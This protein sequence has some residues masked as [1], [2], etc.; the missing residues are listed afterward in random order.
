MLMAKNHNLIFLAIFCLFNASCDGDGSFQATN[1]FENKSGHKVTVEPYFNNVLK[2]PRR[3]ELAK[4]AI[5]LVEQ[6]SGRG[7][8]KGYIYGEVVG[9][10]IVVIFD[11]TLKISHLGL[12]KKVSPKSYAY[13]HQRNL[14]NRNSYTHT[15]LES[16]KK[17]ADNEYRYIF[18]IADYQDALRLNK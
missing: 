15:I 18:T 5:V 2:I 3:F 12:N 16:S 13:E 4:D 6:N 7:T 17:F 10:S 1:Y 8:A 14:K 9:D 11:D